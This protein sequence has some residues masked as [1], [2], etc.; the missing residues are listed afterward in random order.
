MFYS[1]KNIE[2]T[3]KNVKSIKG[4]NGEAIISYKS[5]TPPSGYKYYN[6]EKNALVATSDL[7]EINILITLKKRK[8]VKE[9]LPFVRKVIFP[10]N[11]AEKI[12]EECYPVI[13]NR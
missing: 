7:P 2:T 3:E 5:P 4:P 6:T 12:F 11:S 8:E 13:T 10:S 9:I 1:K